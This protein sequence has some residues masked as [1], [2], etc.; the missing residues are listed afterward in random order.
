M[1]NLNDFIESSGRRAIYWAERFGV[2]TTH[3]S[4]LRHGK[5][6]PSLD[7]A[8]RIARETGGAVPVEVWTAERVE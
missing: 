6:R 1:M 4:E 3:L 7:V 5:K 2:G 8:L